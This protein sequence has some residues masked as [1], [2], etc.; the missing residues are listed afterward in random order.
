MYGTTHD[1]ITRWMI[2]FR[3]GHH[4]YGTEEYRMCGSAYSGTAAKFATA[5]TVIIYMVCFVLG[6]MYL[7]YRPSTR[8]P[9]MKP[10]PDDHADVVR[11]GAGAAAAAGPDMGPLV[12]AGDMMLRRRGYPAEMPAVRYDNCTN[13]HCGNTTNNTNCQMYSSCTFATKRQPSSTLDQLTN[14][15]GAM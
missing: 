14:G 1:S 5:A 13:N 9:T 7:M 12:P 3:C 15:F 6:V 10:P 11:D 2:R 8:S 4:V